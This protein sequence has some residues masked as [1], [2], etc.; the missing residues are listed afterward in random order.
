[1]MPTTTPWLCSICPLRTRCS[2]TPWRLL[3]QAFVGV[4][5]VALV[6]FIVL[7]FNDSLVISQWLN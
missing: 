1:M 3:E 6:V 4:A 2:G 5:I 7:F